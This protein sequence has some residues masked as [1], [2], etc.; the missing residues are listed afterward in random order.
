MWA[1]NIIFQES[2]GECCIVLPI[3][4]TFF[5]AT[6]IKYSIGFQVS[7]VRLTLMNNA[8][9]LI[10][11]N[12]FYLNLSIKECSWYMDNTFSL[13]FVMQRLSLLK[14]LGIKQFGS[15]YIRVKI[16]VRTEYTILLRIVFIILG[17]YLVW[18]FDHE[19]K[20]Q[21]ILNLR[22]IARACTK[23]RLKRVWNFAKA[24]T[25]T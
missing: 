8:P 22:G 13:I 19:S 4:K 17:R 16:L 23:S 10:T 24:H 3:L 12:F 18:P 15:S 1:R 11:N 25:H 5:L 7:F 2:S 14:S 9:L 6:F 20:Y 21:V